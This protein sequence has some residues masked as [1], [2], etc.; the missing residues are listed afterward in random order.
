MKKHYYSWQDIETMCTSVVKQICRDSWMPDYIVG[1]NR[2]GL[3]PGVILSHMLGV[4]CR[5]LNVS[6]RDNKGSSESDLEMA[7]DAFGVNHDRK[8]KNILIVD[9]INDSGATLSWIKKDWEKVINNHNGVWHNNVRFA[10]LTNNSFSQFKDVDYS[11]H[12]IS[13]IEEFGYS[14]W[15]V[16]PWESVGDYE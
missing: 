9:D 16:F 12:N 15:Y 11:G 5:S 4:P 2:G 14:L 13:K 10:T 8:L 6:L 3:I 1:I 7:A